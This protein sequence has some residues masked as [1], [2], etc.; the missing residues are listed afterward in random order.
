VKIVA[1]AKVLSALWLL[2]GIGLFIAFMFEMVNFLSSE[3]LESVGLWL[4]LTLL[5]LASGGSFLLG[6]RI[7]KLDSRVKW[8]GFALSILLVLYTLYIMA[9][10]PFDAIFR[11][12]L[13]LQIYVLALGVT[14]VAYLLSGPESK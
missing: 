11:W 8:M 3:F 12:I 13:V 7:S 4:S 5:A 6:A 2:L 9:I 1:T 14:T 10:T